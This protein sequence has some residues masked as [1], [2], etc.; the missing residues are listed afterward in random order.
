MHGQAQNPVA[1]TEPGRLV[2]GK[3]RLA[4]KSANVAVETAEHSRKL[5]I[6]GGIEGNEEPGKLAGGGNGEGEFGRQYGAIVNVDEVMTS[7]S[8]ETD[9][10]LAAGIPARVQHD[11]AAAPAMGVDEGQDGRAQTTF[12]Q[13]TEDERPFPLAISGAIEV[14]QAAATAIAE[15]D[16]GRRHTLGCRSAQGQKPG[17]RTLHFSIDGLARQSERHLDE[18]RGSLAKPVPARAQGGY[19][20]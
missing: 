10:R 13:C 18:A 2:E 15:V 11:A 6:E 12:A 9:A 5:Q 7:F 1:R 4:R 16:A 3:G 14:L 8:H 17:S 20:K 19:V